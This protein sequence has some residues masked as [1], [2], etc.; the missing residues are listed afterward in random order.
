MQA[1]LDKLPYSEGNAQTAEFFANRPK[2]IFAYLDDFMQNG[3]ANFSRAR[4]ETQPE[5][6]TPTILQHGATTPILL[7]AFVVLFV[8]LGAVYVFQNG[9]F[10]K[11]GGR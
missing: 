3:R 2:Y 1:L 4:A 11:K 7:S 5:Q 9:G 8:L 10:R 6:K